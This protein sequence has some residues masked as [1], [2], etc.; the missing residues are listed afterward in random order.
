MKMQKILKA[1]KVNGKYKEKSL[2][3][4][5][6]ESPKIEETDIIEGEVLQ[7]KTGEGVVLINDF[8]K[9]KA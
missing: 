1:K 2:V 8:E 3:Y 6:I 4:W 5:K 9:N 7:N